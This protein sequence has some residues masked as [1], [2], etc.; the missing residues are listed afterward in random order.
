MILR[1]HADNYERNIWS[2]RRGDD[3]CERQYRSD[4]GRIRQVNE[5]QSWVGQLNNGITLA[6]VAD[7]MGGHQ[8]GDVASELAVDS[9]P[10]HAGASVVK[11]DL[12][13]QEGKMLTASD[14]ARRMRSCLRRRPATSNIIIWARLSWQRC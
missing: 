5:D 4:I 13:L 14:F 11:A 10:Q 7:G 3:D 1:P 8:A 6:I 9:L 2:P 12:S